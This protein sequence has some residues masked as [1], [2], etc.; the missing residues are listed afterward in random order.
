[1]V[2]GCIGIG[3]VDALFY[4]INKGIEEVMGRSSMVLSR[5]VS[6]AIMEFL[7]RKKLVY[8]GMS[9]LEIKKLFVDVFGLAEDLIIIE[10]YNE[11]VFKVIKPVLTAFLEEVRNGNVKPYICSFIGVLSLIY[12]EAKGIRLMLLDVKPQD[13]FINIVFKKL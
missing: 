1:M 7:R 9:I 13:D 12:S 4:G 6:T 2:K 10:R 8:E 5:R 11:V 3:L